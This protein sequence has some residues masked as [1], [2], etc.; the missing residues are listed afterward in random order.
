[1]F[2]SERRS[3]AVSGA[4][5]GFPSGPPSKLVSNVCNSAAL[6]EMVVSHLYGMA[7]TVR[8]YNRPA[9]FFEVAVPVLINLYAGRAALGKADG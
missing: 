3:R 5:G 9:E 4:G 6:R 7:C 2:V 1:M 8:S